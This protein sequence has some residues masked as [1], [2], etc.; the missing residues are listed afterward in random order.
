MDG[1]TDII[2]HEQ[3]MEIDSASKDDLDDEPNVKDDEDEDYV[4]DAAM[5]LSEVSSTKKGTKRKIKAKKGSRVTTPTVSTPSVDDTLAF[6]TETPDAATE[7]QYAE[8]P[9]V[10][11]PTRTRGGGRG[12]GK[13]RKRDSNLL[14]ESG[15][16]HTVG[17]AG[18]SSRGG[19]RS[20]PA[21]S[22]RHG[23]DLSGSKSDYH[24]SG[25]GLCNGTPERHLKKAFA[26]TRHISVQ[27]AEKIIDLY[28]QHNA[29]LERLKRL[30][31]VGDL[32]EFGRVV[33][34][35]AVV[36]PP[37]KKCI[38][39]P[40]RIIAPQP[41]PPTVS[42]QPSPPEDPIELSIKFRLLKKLCGK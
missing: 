26:T 8:P 19:A 25:H 42:T 28:Q 40:R 39:D 6:E 9:Q 17:K 13:P 18:R 15:D 3:D 11:K 38:L 20:G 31:L 24:T 36:P 14:D 23:S 35:E 30:I 41:E 5:Q 27:E 1:D 2:I 21:S 22:K 7:E 10:V 29:D 33:L 12:V 16:S 32:A 4:P 37:K 34:E